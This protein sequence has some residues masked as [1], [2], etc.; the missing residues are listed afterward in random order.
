MKAERLASIIGKLSHLNDAVKHMYIMVRPMVNNLID[1]CKWSV[2]PT[3]LTKPRATGYNRLWLHG[4]V[5]LHPGVGQ[6]A[7]M[8]LEG[9]DVNSPRQLWQQR[10]EICI[11]TDAS[12]IGVGAVWM[13]M[14][15]MGRRIL[16]APIPVHVTGNS[17]MKR[18]TYAM[19]RAMHAITAIDDLDL[20]NVD[21][22]ILTDSAGL[23]ARCFKGNDDMGTTKMLIQCATVAADAGAELAEITWIPR[24]KNL[25]ADLASREVE[26]AGGKLRINRTWF[27]AWFRRLATEGLPV[28][29]VDAYASETNRVL[30]NFTT[31]TT[32][33]RPIGIDA[34]RMHWEPEDVLWAFPPAGLARKAWHHWKQ[35]DS[36]TMYLCLPEPRRGHDMLNA[37]GKQ[38][39]SWPAEVDG[40]DD[41]VVVLFQK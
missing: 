10:R 36:K 26:A 38:Q 34:L 1:F 17:S 30:P 25:E 6:V 19:L 40:E 33:G 12:D 13:D 39:H 15:G 14:I 4:T 5:K 22:H 18:E 23:H 28:P 27:N 20:T 29:N 16:S 11:A 35:T 2:T 32:G 9:W 37:V 21:I 7:R 41:F 3:D 8:I 24:E 31:V